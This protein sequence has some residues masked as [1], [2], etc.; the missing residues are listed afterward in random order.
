MVGKKQS[1]REI[2]DQRHDQVSRLERNRYPLPPK[3]K[4]TADLTTLHFI[5]DRGFITVGPDC[6]RCGPSS[7]KHTMEGGLRITPVVGL[8]TQL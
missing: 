5:E 3:D 4:I 1:K 6:P 2:N 8:V 7:P